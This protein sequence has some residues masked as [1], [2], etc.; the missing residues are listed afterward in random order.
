MV[1]MGSKNKLSKE[2]A[3]IIQKVI[4]KKNIKYYIEPFVGGANMIDKIK[5]P[6]RIGYDKSETLI[7]LL[8]TAQKDINLIPKNITKEQFDK[9]REYRKNKMTLEET[10]LS[11]LEI[12]SAEFL[13]SYS[14]GGFPKGY[15][16]PTKTRNFYQENYKNLCLQSEKLKDI[17]FIVKNYEEIDPNDFKGAVFYLDPPY[18]GTASYDYK[19]NYSFNYEYFWNWV[20]KLSFRNYVFISE[21]TAPSDFVPIWIKDVKR[22]MTLKNNTSATEKL[23]VLENSFAHNFFLTYFE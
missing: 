6:N 22:T 11:L 9:G 20:R 21:Q 14:A 13:G 2:I 1:Y 4:D 10:G 23:F 7:E 16:A 5:C 12:A 18:Y 19:K 17:I 3:P 15:A 8:K